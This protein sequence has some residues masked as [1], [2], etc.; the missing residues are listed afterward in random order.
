[1]S[2][3]VTPIPRLTVLTV[4]AFTLGL[5]DA[6]GSA[7]TS[8]ASDSTLLAFDTTLPAAVGTAATGSAT[9]TARR[10][11]VHSGPTQA[12]QA[13]IEAQTDEDSYLPPDLVVYNPYIA[14]QWGEFSMVSTHA[15][16]F[17]LNWSSVTDGGAAGDSDLLYAADY[18]GDDQILQG[19]GD[20]NQVIGF[21]A[22]VAGGCTV[23]CFANGSGA[24]TAQ[25]YVVGWGDRA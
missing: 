6:A 5:A 8:I 11:H 16:T 4:P 12:T 3:Q 25:C 19:A 20:T 22:P 9:V 14:K 21:N 10:D 13:A 17:S 1:M 24:D 18:S 15:I 7:V 23:R 2:I